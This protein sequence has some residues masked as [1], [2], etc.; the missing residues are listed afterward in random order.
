MNSKHQPCTKINHLVHLTFLSTGLPIPQL[1]ATINNS[2]S[3]VNGRVRTGRHEFRNSSD[4][5][6]PTC[7]FEI[8]V[9]GRVAILSFDAGGGPV[10]SNWFNN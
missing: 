8:L 1:I 3:K 6:L 7:S 5:Y 2:S 9:T 4:V 10:P